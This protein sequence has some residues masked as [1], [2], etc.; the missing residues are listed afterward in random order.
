MLSAI[1]FAISRSLQANVTAVALL[2]TTSIAKLGPE[3]IAMGFLG[4]ILSVTWLIR[5]KVEI[6]IP[7]E[8]SII[9]VSDLRVFETSNNVSLVC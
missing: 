6:S 2:L 5:L 8:Q 4:K 3:S 7:F 9:G 1:L